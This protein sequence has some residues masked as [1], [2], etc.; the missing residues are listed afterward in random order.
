[1]NKYQPKQIEIGMKK[2]HDQYR[3]MLQKY[4]DEIMEKKIIPYLNDKQLSFCMM[5]GWPQ[6]YDVNGDRKPLPKVL[7]NL[8]E[9]CDPE[10]DKIAYYFN[11]Y[12][13]FKQNFSDLDI[14]D[15]R[16]KPTGQLCQYIFS[17]AMCL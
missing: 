9:V 8:M 4:A 10:G 7:E 2:L 17:P 16:K 11:D 14:A 3:D 1:M 12:N 15:H 13:P 6:V 5:N